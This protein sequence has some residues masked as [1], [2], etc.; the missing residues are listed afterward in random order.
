MPKLLDLIYVDLLSVN[1]QPSSPKPCN[2]F[3]ELKLKV[4]I[5]ANLPEYKLFFLAPNDCAP[6]SIVFIECF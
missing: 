4:D 5:S 1:T 2:T 3:M 6:S